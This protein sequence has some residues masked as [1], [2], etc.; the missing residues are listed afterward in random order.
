MQAA[1]EER[2]HIEGRIIELEETLK[3]AEVI[4]ENRVKKQTVALGDSVVLCEVDSGEEWCYVLVSPREVAPA[5]GKISDV[6]PI[7][8]A[9]MG[10]SE[11]EVVEVSAPAGK[12]RCLIKQVS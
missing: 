2:G 8:K 11:G 9:V 12:M 3:T 5:E 4:D 10:R 6:S 7:G 1:R